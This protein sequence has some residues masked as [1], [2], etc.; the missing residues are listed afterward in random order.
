MKSKFLASLVAMMG[1]FV[2]PIA[3]AAVREI[4]AVQLKKMMDAR[5]VQVIFPLSRIE[6]NDLHIPD[7]IHLP[8]EK[9]PEQLPADKDQN[10]AFYCLG[11]S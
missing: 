8:M 5:S 9:I 3:D 4:D 6:F 11:R 1:F 10:L 2:V 7:S